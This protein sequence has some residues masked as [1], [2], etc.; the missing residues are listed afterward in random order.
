M[1]PILKKTEL[2]ELTSP[3][4][5]II[6]PVVNMLPVTHLRSPRVMPRSLRYTTWLLEW[7]AIP[8]SPNMIILVLWSRPSRACRLS[9]RYFRR[10]SFRTM[11][12]FTSSDSAPCLERRGKKLLDTAIMYCIIILYYITILWHCIKYKHKRLCYIINDVIILF[13]IVICYNFLYVILQ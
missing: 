5:G 3:L 1:L 4:C 6:I 11:A 7:S 12:D 9:S 10:P 2:T 13:F 8:W